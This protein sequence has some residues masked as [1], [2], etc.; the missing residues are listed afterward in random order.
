VINLFATTKSYCQDKILPLLGEVIG[1]ADEFLG[2][3]TFEIFSMG[4]P[5]NI[6]TAPD[7]KMEVKNSNAGLDY[8]KFIVITTKTGAYIYLYISAKTSKC[9]MINYFTM[10]WITF[11]EV[12]KYLVENW[13]FHGTGKY[14]T[15]KPDE[16]IIFTMDMDESSPYVTLILKLKKD[17]KL[18]YK[19]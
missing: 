5:T 9:Y 8:N 17:S 15:G 18:L 2:K 3:T 1:N 16:E 4:K 19:D 6:T 7:W 12:E 14:F 11:K 10:N 13:Y